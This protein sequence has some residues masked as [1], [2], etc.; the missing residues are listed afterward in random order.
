LNTLFKQV[1]LYVSNPIAS[2][3]GQYFILGKLIFLAL[4]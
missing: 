3:P 4:F 2:V 1:L